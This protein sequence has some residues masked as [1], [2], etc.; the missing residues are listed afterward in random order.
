MC[1]YIMFQ[2][3]YYWW[4]PLLPLL[5]ACP[6]QTLA[7]NSPPP[8]FPRAEIAVF[9]LLPSSLPP[10]GVGRNFDDNS[11][12]WGQRRAAF[13]ERDH[14]QRRPQ[15]RLISF[16]NFRK[17]R[18]RNSPFFTWKKQRRMFLCR[19]FPNQKAQLLPSLKSKEKE[20]E[21][22]SF[23]LFFP[24]STFFRVCSIYHCSPSPPPFV[25]PPLSLFSGSGL[26]KFTAQKVQT[27]C[28]NSQAGAWQLL[29][30]TELLGNWQI[31]S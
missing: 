23:L 24:F 7:I 18:L 26:T 22:L 27:L 12:S 8:P 3:S 30:E 9:F 19:F 6:M 28:K 17:G 31:S 15:R 4:N 20:M 2:K 14:Y 25:P 11:A 5:H 16:E 1:R 29:V 10:S 13:N 21:S